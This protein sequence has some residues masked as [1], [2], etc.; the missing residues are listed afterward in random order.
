MGVIITCFLVLLV[1]IRKFQSLQRKNKESQDA[2]TDELRAS[3]VHIV[4]AIFL[5]VFFISGCILKLNF[6]IAL[7]VSSVTCVADFLVA[8]LV[9]QKKS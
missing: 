3:R 8:K 7:I 6:I 2:S 5:I 1:A 4:F 9:S